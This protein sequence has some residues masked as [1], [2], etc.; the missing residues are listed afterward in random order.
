MAP[1][2][3]SAIILNRLLAK[4]DQTVLS[5]DSDPRIRTSQY[6]RNRVGVNIEHAR[7]LLLTQ[8]KQS[9]AIKSQSQKQKSQTDLQQKRELIKRLNARLQELNQLDDEDDEDDE[10]EDEDEDVEDV[11]SRYAPAVKNASAGLDT[12]EPQETRINEKQASELRAR[13]RLQVE[14]NRDAASSTAREHLFAG[15]PREPQP[16]SETEQTE[17]LMA[18]NRGEQENLT[19]GLLGLARALKES[20]QQFSSSLEA[21]KDVLKR[22]EGGL[23]KSAQGMEVAE[24]KMSTLRKMSE[25]QGWYGRI[26][27][28]AFIAALWLACFL[29]VFIGPKLRF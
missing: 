8:E 29:L 21:E 28:Y 24:R 7:T 9:S 6:E 13:R 23:D 26:K 5:A 12:G 20:S 15:R 19:S 22:A 17:M 27:L 14:G 16:Q 4:L 10:D 11:L 18:H 1:I 25:G 2:D 3:T